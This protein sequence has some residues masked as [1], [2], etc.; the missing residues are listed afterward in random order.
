MSFEGR[1]WTRKWSLGGRGRYLVASA[2][3][4]GILVVPLAV[5]ASHQTG[6]PIQTGKRTYVNQETGVIANNAG[7]SLRFSNKQEGQG[8]GLVS[9]CRSA[10]GRE[11]CI[12]GDNLRDGLAFLF[13]SR[14]GSVGGRIEV[15]GQ[16][17]KPFTT[18]ATGVADGLNAD[19]VDSREVACPANTREVAGLCYDEAPRTAATAYAAADTCKMAGGQ[20]PNTLALRAIRGETGIDLGDDP[21][22]TDHLSDSVHSDGA[23][24]QVM[25]VGDD[26]DVRAV[27]ATEQHPY[28]CA[29]EL[30]RGAS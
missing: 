22:D 25:A 28:R 24:V 23:T 27:P 30:V 12:Y 19:R 9:G 20:L 4:L 2:A 7:Y 26:G 3:V 18:N 1:G 13:R 8:G 5:D 16:N 14:R 11:A 21:Q 15:L 10:A 29:F 6:Q 17:A